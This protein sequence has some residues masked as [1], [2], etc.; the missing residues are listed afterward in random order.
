MSRG[1]KRSGAGRP[2][3]HT[4]QA[5]FKIRIAT[6]TELR[7]KIR[8]YQRSQFVDEAICEKLDKLV[9]QSSVS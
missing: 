4:I 8:P 9:E 7:K 1:G 3:A 6:I 5:C 2:L